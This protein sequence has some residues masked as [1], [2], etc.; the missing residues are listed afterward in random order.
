MKIV[1]EAKTEKGKE[2]IKLFY[3][4]SKNLF[5]QRMVGLKTNVVSDEPYIIVA[6]SK[7]FQGDPAKVKEKAVYEKMKMF[8]FTELEPKK[9]YMVKVV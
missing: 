2:H 8:W 5:V 6:E 3:A 4:K 9:D 1:I 7:V